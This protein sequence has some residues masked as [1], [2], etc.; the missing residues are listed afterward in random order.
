MHCKLYSV[1]GYLGYFV[2]GYSQ[3]LLQVRVVH[4][5]L[6]KLLSIILTGDNREPGLIYASLRKMS[7]K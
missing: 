2:P 6:L 1:P 3:I 4:D 7:V 5:L